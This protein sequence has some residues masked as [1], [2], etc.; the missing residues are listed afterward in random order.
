MIE[1]SKAQA[2]YGAQ[3]K[4]RP[5]REGEKEGGKEDL[6]TCSQRYDRKC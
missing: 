4:G 3:E 5:G 2:S 1:S 6:P